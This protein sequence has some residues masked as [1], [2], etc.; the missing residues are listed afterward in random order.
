MTNEYSVGMVIFLCKAFLLVITPTKA[1]ITFSDPVGGVKANVFSLRSIIFCF[2][3][4]AQ[5]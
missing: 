5:A 3:A 2:P 4:F 1:G